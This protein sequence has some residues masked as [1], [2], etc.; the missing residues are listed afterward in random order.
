MPERIYGMS[1]YV[2]QDVSTGLYLGADGSARADF[3]NARCFSG[4]HLREI[5]NSCG[6]LMNQYVYIKL[7]E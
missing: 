5:Y 7:P 3:D 2:L 1:E 4:S 6:A